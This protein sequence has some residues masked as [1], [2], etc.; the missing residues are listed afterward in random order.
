MLLNEP[1]LLSDVELT[2][3]T[4]LREKATSDLAGFRGGPLSWSNWNLEMLVFVEGG[5]PEN[6]VKTLGTW[7]QL[8]TNTTHIWHRGGIEPA[9]KLRTGS[10]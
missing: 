3:N 6:T 7:R 4:I 8:T 2:C 9:P 10:W 1:E 5:K